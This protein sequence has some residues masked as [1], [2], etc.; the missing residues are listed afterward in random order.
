MISKTTTQ[1][2]EEVEVKLRQD[3]RLRDF[4][5]EVFDYNGVFIL[6]GEVPS[7]AISKLAED[8]VRH[9]DG[10]VSVT[11]ELYIKPK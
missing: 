7:E 6:Q 1:L 8:L 5:I 10:V 2:K 9:V 3:S 11:N 4:P